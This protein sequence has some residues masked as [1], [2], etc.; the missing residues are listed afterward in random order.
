MKLSISA[1]RLDGNWVLNI[2]YTK[3]MMLLKPF[4]VQASRPGCLNT[5]C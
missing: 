1:D 3:T 2:H 5:L 4:S